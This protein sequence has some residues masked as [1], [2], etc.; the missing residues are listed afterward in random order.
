MLSNLFSKKE[1][2]DLPWSHLSAIDQLVDVD[3]KSKEKPVLLFKH[4]TRC[5]I[6]AMTLSRFERSYDE[7]AAFEPYFLDLIAHRDVSDEIAR[8]Y[9]I[10]HES[11]QAIL[12]KN[13]K[14][15]FNASHMGINFDE[16]NSKSSE[17]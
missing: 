4:S 3:S 5:S 14:A 7:S 15:I 17:S 13:G 8:K 16:L 6:S 11:P 12:I 10:R 2:V 9:G 1:R